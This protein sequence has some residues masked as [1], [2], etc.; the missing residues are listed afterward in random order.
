MQVNRTAA[1]A[2]EMGDVKREF[3]DW[4]ATKLAAINTMLGARNAQ[5]IVVPTL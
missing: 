3:D 1:I 4:V 2:R 5:K